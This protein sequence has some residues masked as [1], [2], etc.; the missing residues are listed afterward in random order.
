[1]ERAAREKLKERNA[2]KGEDRVQKLPVGE[3][4]AWE[5]P[6]EKQSVWTVG[7]KMGCELQIMLD[8]RLAN[9]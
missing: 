6:G 1:M 2:R 8:D 5:L 3:N 9:T 7:M 4:G